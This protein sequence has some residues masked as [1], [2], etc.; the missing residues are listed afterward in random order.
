LHCWHCCFLLRQATLFA[1]L[2]GCIII[3]TAT[4]SSI[5]RINQAPQ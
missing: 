2:S 4:Y 3:V 1:V 5:R